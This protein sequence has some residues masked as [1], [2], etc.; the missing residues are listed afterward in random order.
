[1]KPQDEATS[2]IIGLAGALAD[3]ID[4]FEPE[5]LWLDHVVHDRILADNIV[6]IVDAIHRLDSL[7]AEGDTSAS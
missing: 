6:D 5:A 1:M 7:T 3:Y 4:G 2:K